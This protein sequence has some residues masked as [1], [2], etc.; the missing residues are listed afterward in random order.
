M[1]EQVVSAYVQKLGADK[2]TAGI[3][4]GRIRVDERPSQ[5]VEVHCNKNPTYG[6][7]GF[8]LELLRHRIRDLDDFYQI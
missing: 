6:K 4:V 8:I 2:G 5:R 7:R 3:K 1:M